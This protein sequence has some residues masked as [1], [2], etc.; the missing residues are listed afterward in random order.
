MPDHFWPNLSIIIWL[1]AL[2]TADASGMLRVSLQSLT[3]MR[4][5][6]FEMTRDGH[7]LHLNRYGYGSQ[8]LEFFRYFF[9]SVADPDDG[10]CTLTMM[11]GTGTRHRFV[12][13]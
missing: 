12:Y 6:R 13:F 8:N 2:K 9:A 5:M 10:F 3:E 7:R 11:L 1:S 4:E